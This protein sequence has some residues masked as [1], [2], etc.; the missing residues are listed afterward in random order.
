MP[1][2]AV[3]IAAICLL[4]ARVVGQMP[5]P[6]LVGAGLVTAGALA[7]LAHIAGVDVRGGFAAGQP[8]L[9]PSLL[10]AVS[11]EDPAQRE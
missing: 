10:A 4:R 7:A 5:R 3:R 11:P 8:G 6:L 2:Q 1:S 9:V